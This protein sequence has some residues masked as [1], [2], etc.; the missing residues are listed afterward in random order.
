MDETA[1]DH[2]GIVAGGGRL[3]QLL[4]SECQSQKRPYTV[5]ALE[6]HADSLEE[7]PAEQIRIGQAGTC[8]QTFHD[9]GVSSVVMAG[10]VRRPNL[11]ELR[12]DWRTV[13]FLAR[14]GLKAFRNAASV[15]DDKLLRL[16]IAEIESEGFKVIGVDDVL[17]DSIARLGPVGRLT[18]SAKDKK[19][20]EAGLH[21]A[22]ALG[23]ADIGQAVVVQNGVVIAR[24]GLAGTDALIQSIEVDQHSADKPIL[25][26]SSKPQQD[27]RADLPVIGPETVAAC[28]SNGFGG[29]AVEAGGA[30]LIDPFIISELADEGGI[31]VVGVGDVTKNQ[32][33][34]SS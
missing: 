33:G 4:I 5:V 21:A 20:I 6:G 31:F 9:N 34:D 13:K 28:V 10:K 8:F 23:R 32:D 15:G 3:P 17:S 1:R 27:R 19:S 7:A 30:L 11:F 16:V 25:V 14:T 12:P 29:L 18:P 22:R 2:L 26:K 24:E